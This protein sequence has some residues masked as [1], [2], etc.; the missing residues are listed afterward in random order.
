MK[1]HVPLQSA[2]GIELE[3]KVTFQDILKIWHA[4]PVAGCV[5][6]GSEVFALLVERNSLNPQREAKDARWFLRNVEAD[7][8]V[9]DDDGL[10]VIAEKHR[11][12]WQREHRRGRLPLSGRTS[13]RVS[14]G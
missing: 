9:E 13:W 5:V 1:S 2:S 11:A 7:C 14:R 12:R 3:G 10:G 6:C 4:L 8:Y